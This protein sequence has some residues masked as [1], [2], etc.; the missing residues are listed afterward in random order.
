[1]KLLGL[2]RHAKS[3]WAD[4]RARDFDR[5]LNKRGRTG[6]AIM[7][8]H[9]RDH[10]V[11]WDHVIS[12][13]AVRCTETV[14]IAAEAAGRPLAVNWDRRIYLASSATLA[15]LLR[16]Q[17]EGFSATLMVGHNPGLEDLIFDLVPDDGSSPLRD[18]VEVK[19]PT[20]AYAVLELDIDR[21]ADL[22]DNCARLVHLTRPRDLDPTLGPQLT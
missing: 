5:P 16:E 2:F 8:R 3:D 20:A 12:S 15:D 10:G 17:D 18:V 14:E 22:A 1:M 11:A 4:P 13:P 9:I 6:A 7:G 19:F 21:W